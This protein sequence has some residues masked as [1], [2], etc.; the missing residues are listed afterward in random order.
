[1]HDS[2]VVFFDLE[3]VPRHDALKHIRLVSD[4]NN[5][6]RGPGKATILIVLNPVHLIWIVTVD[7]LLNH[8][9]LWLD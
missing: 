2:W 7:D 5:A 8:G 9:F 1:M 4:F 3:V 6:T